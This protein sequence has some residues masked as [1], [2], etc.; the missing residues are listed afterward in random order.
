[1]RLGN[2]L[3]RI[4]QQRVCVLAHTQAECLLSCY[5]LLLTHC[6]LMAIMSMGTLGPLLVDY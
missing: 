2:T 5:V 3:R 1:M 6:T 4:K